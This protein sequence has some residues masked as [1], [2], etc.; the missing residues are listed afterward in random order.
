MK[1]VL[2]RKGSLV[3]CVL[4]FAVF[5]GAALAGDVVVK[6]GTM[7][8][9]SLNVS[10]GVVDITG[11]NA[12]AGGPPPL[13]APDVLVAAGGTGGSW[14][15]GGAGSDII[16]TAGAGGEGTE[17]SGGDGGDIELNPG[18]PG[19]GYEEDGEPGNIYLA[20]NGGSVAI[21][22]SFTSYP[23]TVNA[24]SVSGISIWS[25]ADVSATG[26]VTRTSVYDKSKGSALDY[27]C[28]A[29]YYLDAEGKVVHN[30]F[31]GYKTYSSTDFSRPEIESYEYE[32][33][34]YTRTVYPYQKVEEA[35]SL[36]KEV[37][38]L[39]QAVFELKQELE[40]LKAQ[41]PK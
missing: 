16:L 21:R 35:V 5:C 4:V 7:D 11:P 27:V 10:D 18:I 34:T 8:V 3:A 12:P 19:E 9:N 25:Q 6:E 24:A 39:R 32:G 20:K 17:E 37:E 14:L 36:D 13:A 30:R 15:V 28:D 38:V 2:K 31:Y 33:Q 29:D 41:L 22:G 40:M 1:M 26:Y 23:L